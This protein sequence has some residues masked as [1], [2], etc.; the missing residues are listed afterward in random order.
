MQK[1]GGLLD[2]GKNKPVNND[3]QASGLGS[4]VVVIDDH[5]LGQNKGKKHEHQQI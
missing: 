4:R 3:T 5:S 2:T 1:T